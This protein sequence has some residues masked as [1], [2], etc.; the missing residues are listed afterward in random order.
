[1]S[2]LKEKLQ[3][4]RIHSKSKNISVFNKKRS[5]E[6]EEAAS[7]RLKSSEPTNETL[8]I[9]EKNGVHERALPSSSEQKKRKMDDNATTLKTNKQ[10]SYQGYIDQLE[11]CINNQ[12][13]TSH[14]F[15]SSELKEATKSSVSTSKLIHIANS[16]M[17]HPIVKKDLLNRSN[18]ENVF[19]SLIQSVVFDNILNGKDVICEY[20]SVGSYSSFDAQSSNN[21]LEDCAL[22]YL[23]PLLSNVYKVTKSKKINNL[24]L[25]LLDS[26]EILTTLKTKLEKNLPSAL[27]S[28]TISFIQN[29]T[30]EERPVVISTLNNIIK[31]LEERPDLFLKSLRCVAF[32]LGEDYYG[33]LPELF[34]TLS[35]ICKYLPQKTS[36]QTLFYSNSISSKTSEFVLNNLTRAGPPF[37]KMSD[38]LAEDALIKQSIE[39]DRSKQQHSYISVGYPLK[40]VYLFSLI[41]FLAKYRKF[42]TIFVYFPT[43][44]LCEFYSS[45]FVHTKDYKSITKKT[46]THFVYDGMA[47]TPACKDA[48]RA[49]VVHFEMPPD[50]A[51]YLQR[52][53]NIRRSI[54]LYTKRMSS[55]S[56]VL[57]S[58]KSDHLEKYEKFSTE[59]VDLSIQ[60]QC[61]QA[62]EKDNALRDALKFALKSFRMIHSGFLDS[63]ALRKQQSN[64][65]SVKHKKKLLEDSEILQPFAVTDTNV[66]QKSY[67]FFR[68]LLLP[69][70]LC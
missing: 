9:T 14:I 2:L 26:E 62:V 68:G 17:I 50:N 6:E 12:P 45:L 4:A 23:I 39:M 3:K 22:S 1:M 65:K 46:A 37:V 18:E 13:E 60:F 19:L 16:N 48:S 34:N 53:G 58:E 8:E 41:G 55:A 32:H 31:V 56:D 15:T 36:R 30:F 5:N 64:I 69:E 67:D 70:D 47:H 7:S 21:V 28:G 10:K 49:V 27:E 54:V 42:Q 35:S 63:I 44:E 57:F 40:L 61:E 52:I 43:A 59:H 38:I 66:V 20:C 25:V 51:T 29:A 33:R 24:G 11:E